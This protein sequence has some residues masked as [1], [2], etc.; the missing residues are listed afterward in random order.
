MKKPSLALFL[1][2]LP[3]CFLVSCYSPQSL[4]APSATPGITVEV[5]ADGLGLGTGRSLMSDTNITSVEILVTDS[6]DQPAGSGNL[7]KNATNWS[8]NIIVTAPGTLTFTALARGSAGGPVVYQGSSSTPVNGEGVRVSIAVSMANLLADV[9]PVNGATGV[10]VRD[11]TGNETLEFTFHFTASVDPLVV[12]TLTF[13]EPPRVYKVGANYAK[14]GYPLEEEAAFAFSQTIYPNDTLKVK[15]SF[16]Y[17]AQTY[18]A[19]VLSGFNAPGGLT[20]PDQTLPTYT[21]TTTTIPLTSQ[22]S[23]WRDRV[24][25]FSLTDRF[26]DGNGANNQ[27]ITSGNLDYVLGDGKTYQGGDFVGMTAKLPYLKNLGITALWIT[28][29]VRQAWENAAFTSYHGYWAQDFYAVD[30]HLGTLKDFRDFVK[31]AHAQGIAVVMDVVVNHVGPLS[32]YDLNSDNQP[33]DGEWEPVYSP[34]AYETHKWLEDVTPAL[35]WV[36]MPNRIKPNF[37]PMPSGK[38]ISDFLTRKGGNA[39]SGTGNEVTEGDFSGLR[40]VNTSDAAVGQRLTEIFQW[41]IANSDIDGYRIDT[42]KHVPTAFWSSFCADLRTYAS[43]LTTTPAGGKKFYTL[44]EVYDGSAAGVGT[45]TQTGMLD[46][47][48]GFPMATRVFDWNW[49]ASNGPDGDNI[50]IFKDTGTWSSRPKTN[51]VEAALAEI[52]GSTNLTTV[53]SNGD[54]QSARQKI[55]YFL[56]NH[57]LNRFLNGTSDNSNEVPSSGEITNLQLALGW[58]LTWEGIPVVYYGTE[59][60]YKQSLA[61]SSGGEHGSGIGNVNK[62]NRPNLWQVANSTQGSTAFSETS[63]TY[64]LISALAGART[65]Y[66]ELG[67]GYAKVVWSDTDGTGA[68]TGILA[69]LRHYGATAANTDDDILVVINT[70]SLYSVGSYASGND[71]KVGG[72]GWGWGAGVTLVP[73]TFAGVGTSVLNSTLYDNSE[74][75]LSP[76]QTTT[77]NQITDSTDIAVWFKVPPNSITI[78]KKQ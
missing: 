49:T 76:N 12:G 25:Y 38:T 71:M 30:P 29:P 19:P 60:N 36:T 70:S 51:T 46:S 1:L 47:V 74:F 26:N 15:P 78:L 18:K 65:T 66:P 73:V 31:A 39:T 34:T 9:L 56:D 4:N 57:D 17:A 7:S 24:M 2:L 67:K 52:M 50:T 40:D 32:Y 10:A 27:F 58:L 23:D 28:S 35:S 64:K 59:Q 44:A 11:A 3:G 68:D 41:W 37:G 6:A 69:Y 43:G 16:G 33:G 48:L 63:E 53:Q 75:A 55:G 62:G 22:V 5:Q 45:Y 42:V 8:G 72:S 13:S 54:G 21:M 14:V 61:L 77:F 20:L